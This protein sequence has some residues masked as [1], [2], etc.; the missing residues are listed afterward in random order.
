[1]KRRKLKF[2]KIINR[3]NKENC[4]KKKMKKER[5]MGKIRFLFFLFLF[6]LRCHRQSITRTLTK[7][8]THNT[9][10]QSV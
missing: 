10:S 1:M 7:K 8:T 3:W 9:Q 5:W 4:Q 2:S 6:S